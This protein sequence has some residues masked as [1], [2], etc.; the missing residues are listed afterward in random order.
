MDIG[1]STLPTERSI[2]IAVLAKRAEELGFDSIWV[3]EQPILPVRLER[4]VPR[5][6]GDL[7]DPLIALTR[8]SALTTAIKLGTA[9][10]VVSE[11]NPIILAKEVATL[12]MY[13]GGR[14]LF[15][16]GVGGLRE[17]AE[18]LGADFPHRWTQGK[19]A[20]MAMKELW[21]REE[22]EYH[23][24]YYD[25][26]PVYCFPSPAQRPH[27]PI[28]LGSKAPNVFK[29]I[30]AWGDGWLPL[31]VSAEEIQEGRVEL[32]RMAAQVGRD[33]GS[34]EISVMGIP[35]ERGAVQRYADAGADRAIIG[36]KTD[37]EGG[38]LEELEQIAEAVL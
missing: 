2:D 37:D 14:L 8:A 1:I 24:R 16:I 13:S 20:I 27:P 32:D 30:A 35:A 26:P 4:H 18:I 7:V 22:S 38:S 29:W 11:R 36:L 9:V 28:I 23:G 25:F 17:E 15:G 33:P 31:N 19:E 34:L 5:L 21:T 10:V 12:D 6:W 3:P